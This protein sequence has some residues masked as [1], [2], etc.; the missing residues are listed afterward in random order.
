MTNW[1]PHSQVNEPLSNKWRRGLVILAGLMIWMGLALLLA[2]PMQAK[3]QFL[4]RLRAAYP[5][6]V[7]SP[8]DDC[9]LC[10]RDGVP[11]GPINKFADNFFSYK[12]DLAALEPLDSDGDGFTN[13]E[14]LTALTFPGD[15]DSFP[16]GEPATEAGE[17]VAQDP[18]LIIARTL[19]HVPET[20]T[21]ETSLPAYQ[22]AAFSRPAVKIKGNPER[23]RE[24]YAHHCAR[25]H[26]TQGEGGVGPPLAGRWW[27]AP[28]PD[29]MLKATITDGVPDTLMPAW[30]QSQGGD[31]SV[32]EVNNLVA[33]ILN[34]AADESPH[35][36]SSGESTFAA[37]LRG[38][39]GLALLVIGSLLVGLVVF[40][41]GTR[42]Q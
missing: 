19:A 36:V 9:V 24:I 13:L 1:K 34:M 23:G 35:L 32:Y 42:E 7:D 16:E 28:R 21:L 2:S 18:A 40:F 17:T 29:L 8:I 39:V 5:N 20:E 4:D 25:C 10:H 6:I 26:G 3:P 14:E 11:D 37:V 41:R 31:L 12:A 27:T 33:F 15:P 22:A 30:G 38:S